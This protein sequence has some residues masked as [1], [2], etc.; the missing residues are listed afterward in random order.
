MG[1]GERST[2]IFYAETIIGTPKRLTQIIL[3]L[4]SFRDADNE[5]NNENVELG[6]GV[7]MK[8]ESKCSGNHY[9]GNKL[10]RELILNFT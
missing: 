1:G 2:S 8:A 9:L 4:S 5:Q 10:G 7:N 6:V 3:P